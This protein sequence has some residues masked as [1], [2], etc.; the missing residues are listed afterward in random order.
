MLKLL[1]SALAL[2]A[3]QAMAIEE[4]SH[5]VLQSDPPFEVRHYPSFVVAETELQGDFDSASRSGFRRVAGYI[6]GDNRQPTGDSRKIAMT[7]PV[8]VTPKADGWRLHFVLPSQENLNQLPQPVNPE[9]RLR[10]V[11]EHRMATVVFSG[12][13]TQA[14]IER[15]TQQLRDWA[16]SRQLTLVGPPQVARYNDPFTLPWNRRNEILIEVA[17]NDTDAPPNLR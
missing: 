3:T 1:I 16:Q 2:W 5:R 4:P 17:P 15:H 11:P 12:F 9:V 13:T 7:A 14:S 8:T 10:Q 6:F